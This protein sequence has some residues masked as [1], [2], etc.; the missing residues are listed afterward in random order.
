MDRSLPSSGR[1]E[2]ACW[3]LCLARVEGESGRRTICH[4][5]ATTFGSEPSTRARRGIGRRQRLIATELT[6]LAVHVQLDGTVGDSRGPE[7]PG[8]SSQRCVV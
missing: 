7:S 1:R 6:P 2:L 8:P 4:P 3:R 5:S